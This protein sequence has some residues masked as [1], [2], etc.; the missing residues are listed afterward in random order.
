MLLYNDSHAA[1]L[2]SCNSVFQERTKHIEVDCHYIR[3]AIVCGNL[4]A[5]RVPTKEQSVADFFP[6]AL[7]KIFGSS[8][9]GISGTVGFGI[10]G[11]TGLG[12]SGIVGFGCSGSVS[13]GTSENA[14]LAISGKVGFGISGTVGI[15]TSGTVCFGISGIVGLGS[16][17]RGESGGIPALGYQESVRLVLEN[18]RKLWNFQ[19]LDARGDPK[20]LR[21]SAPY[22]PL[23]IDDKVENILLTGHSCCGGIRDLM[24]M[25]DEDNSSSFIKNSV[26]IGKAARSSTKAT[27]SNLSFD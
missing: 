25:E 16:S 20:A 7:G 2:I 24:S 3:D 26:V 22:F 1:L 15:E 5:R 9:L 4:D 14:G 6:K 27:T 13:F 18:F 17:G 8:G 12:I 19:A 11:T 10:S 21:D 23:P